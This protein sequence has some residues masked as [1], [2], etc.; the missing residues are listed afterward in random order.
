MWRPGV[1]N[2]IIESCEGATETHHHTCSHCVGAHA[3][4]FRHGECILRWPHRVIGESSL[5]SCHV[6]SRGRTAGTRGLLQP[7]KGCLHLGGW[8]T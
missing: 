5:I 6:S 2:V 8:A 4:E 3:E 1:I 7:E